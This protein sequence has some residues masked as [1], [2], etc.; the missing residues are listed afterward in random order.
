[1]KIQSKRGN[2]N[3]EVFVWLGQGVDK[4][5]NATTLKWSSYLGRN[6]CFVHFDFEIQKLHFSYVFFFPIKKTKCNDFVGSKYGFHP[7]CD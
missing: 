6:A 1:L 7:K 4:S 2:T 5:P 3:E